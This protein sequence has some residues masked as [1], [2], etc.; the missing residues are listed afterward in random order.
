M[1]GC[2]W[3]GLGGKAASRKPQAAISS[4]DAGRGPAPCREPTSTEETIR[5]S[6]TT[7]PAATEV[8]SCARR[9]RLCPCHRPTLAKKRQVPL[10]HPVEHPPGGRRGGDGA[11]ELGLVTKDRKVADR[12]RTVCDRDGQVGEDTAREV[13]RQRLVGADERCVPRA[14]EPGEPRHLPQKLGARVGHHTL[15]VSGQLEPSC[16][17]ATLHLESAFP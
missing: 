1:I 13:D 16:P 11:E 2:P 4:S 15:A 8:R 10:A 12:V 5:A 7:T 6:S 14:S 17:R 3:A 9:P